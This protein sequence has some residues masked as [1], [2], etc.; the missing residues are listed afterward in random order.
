MKFSIKATI[1]TGAT[2]LF[3]S[4]LFAAQF[5]IN[6]SGTFT[7]QAGAGVVFGSSDPLPFNSSI[8][9]DTSLGD[10]TVYPAGTILNPGKTPALRLIET[11]T[12]YSASTVVS[13]GATLGDASWTETSDQPLGEF[14]FFSLMVVGGLIDGTTPRITVGSNDI[15][16]EDEF[17]IGGLVCSN[18]LYIRDCQIRQVGAAY[19]GS[20][21]RVGTITGVINQV[22]EVTVQTTDELIDDAVESISQ[23]DVEEAVV[24][25]L[26]SHLNIAQKAVSTGNLN[27]LQ[28]AMNAMSNYVSAQ[29]GKKLL[30]ADADAIEGAI[31]SILDSASS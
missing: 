2:A 22:T 24:T 1:L 4:N 7:K 31:A 25:V 30:E 29:R 21:G 23:L 16:V 14:G 5:Q 13:F 12:V 9:I 17:T 11:L 6:T 18:D 28:N 8:L 26:S 10:V 20:A 15:I 19:D 27:K 3:A